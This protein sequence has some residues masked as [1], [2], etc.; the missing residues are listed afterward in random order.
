MR[1]PCCLQNIGDAQTVGGGTRQCL[2]A[3]D[4]E[5]GVAIPLIEDA[6]KLR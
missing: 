3:V 1:A 4:L 2:R 5:E 6:Q